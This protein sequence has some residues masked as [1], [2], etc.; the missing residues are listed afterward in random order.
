MFV[1]ADDGCRLH[2]VAGQSDGVPLI[3]LNSLGTDVSLW[4]GQLRALAR[5]GAA[6]RY[7]T[8]GHGQSDAPAGEYSLERLGRDLLAVADYI[9][10]PAVDLCGISIGGLTTLQVALC[11]PH[12]VRR[13]IVANTAARIG[14]VRSWDDRMRAV[15]AGGLAPLA[16]AAMARWFTPAFR[17][18]HPAT[19]ARFHAVFERTNPAGYAGCCAALRDGDLSASVRHVACPTLVI[20]G[21]HDEATPPEQGRW[22]AAEVPNARYVEL[23]ASHLSNVECAAAFNDAVDRFLHEEHHG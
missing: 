10:A 18:A 11:A 22:L 5:P 1:T 19:V 3:L 4:D 23:D 16:E 6:W 12:R 15:C 13:L 20:V 21:A 17:R 7:D 2:V 9:G 8:R 14:D